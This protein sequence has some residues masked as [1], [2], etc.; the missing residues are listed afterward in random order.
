MVAE[1]PEDRLTEV[2]RQLEAAGYLDLIWSRTVVNGCL[3]ANCTPTLHHVLRSDDRFKEG[4][5]HLLHAD[6]GKHRVDFRSHRGEFGKGS[7]Q[8]VIDRK[9]GALYADV[10]AHSPY[11]DVVGFVAHNAE[12]LK[13]KIKGWFV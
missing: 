3:R 7:L 9:T 10:D 2:E 4:I 1:T 12:V 5:G 8:I 13:N 6:V 11:D